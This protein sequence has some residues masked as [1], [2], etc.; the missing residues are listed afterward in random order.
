MNWKQSS[1]HSK[2][3][4]KKNRKKILTVTLR[5]RSWSTKVKTGHWLVSRLQ[6]PN[7][8]T[9][10]NQKLSPLSMVQVNSK[11]LMTSKNPTWRPLLP[12]KASSVK[13]IR[14]FEAL[15]SLYSP[16]SYDWKRYSIGGGTKPLYRAFRQ[17]WRGDCLVGRTALVDRP[18]HPPHWV[19]LYFS[20]LF[21]IAGRLGSTSFVAVPPAF[22]MPPAVPI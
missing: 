20:T 10:N 18:S 9:N 21:Y 16:P 1:N 19:T 14:C 7:T 22:T 2:R 13:I 17:K 11:D 12:D 8:E 6:T 4:P 3:R 5:L 15:V